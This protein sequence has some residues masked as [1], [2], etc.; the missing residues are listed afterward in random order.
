MTGTAR[1]R[2]SPVSTWFFESSAEVSLWWAFTWDTSIFTCFVH[3]DRSTHI[4][5]PQISLSPI[6]Q[7]CSFQIP[8]RSAKPLDTAMNRYAHLATSLTKQSERTSTLLRGLPTGRLSIYRVLQEG[9]RERL[10]YYSCPLLGGV[11]LS[12]RTIYTPGPSLLFL[13][14]LTG[15]NS[16]GDPRC[17]LG[18]GK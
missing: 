9:P 2:G 7:P 17:R 10:W 8:D 15:E 4:R 3:P 16:P 1:E 12:C 11:C 18:K 14:Q 6:F 5:L 13:H